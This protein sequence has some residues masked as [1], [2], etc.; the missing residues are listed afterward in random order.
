MKKEYKCPH[1]KRIIIK[2]IDKYLKK[3]PEE[4][5][6]QCPYCGIHIEVIKIL[7]EVGK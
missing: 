5:W 3:Y 6:V 1:C 7:N 4:K 2:D